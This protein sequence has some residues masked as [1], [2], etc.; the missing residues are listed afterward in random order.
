MEIIF[1]MSAFLILYTYAVYPLML[2]VFFRPK[3]KDYRPQAENPEPSMVTILVCAHNEEKVI[4]ERID[5]LLSLDYPKE[6]TEIVIAS[7]G[8][9]DDTDNIVKEY[10]DAGV[11]LL[12]FS[13][14]AGKVNTINRSLSDL[15]GDIIVLTDANTIFERDAV[16]RLIEKFKYKDIGC[17][18]G[19]LHFRD[20]GI[21]RL[22]GIYWRFE[23]FLKK[24]EGARGSLL[25][26]NGGIYAFR[27]ELFINLPNDTIVE[28]FVL[29]MKILEKGH[30]VYYE[31]LAI[32][33]EDAAQ[34]LVQEFER[35]VRIG[36]GDY[37]A[38]VYTWKILNPLRGFT[39]FAYFSHKVVRWFVPFFIISLF[40]TNLFLVNHFF[41]RMVFMSQIIFYITAGLGN[42]L[43]RIDFKCKYI[44][45]PYYF[46]SMNT[47]LLIGFFR[48]CLGRQSVKWIRTQR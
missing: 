41:Y 35:R 2:A 16:S 23:Q 45:L 12:S 40:F 39:A 21:G 24:T 3:D 43:H 38:L 42:V 7:D 44:E 36:A 10:K 34:K 47:A 27:K 29:P 46:V 15:N 13:D 14:R 4:R 8:S 9:C 48:F 28:D 25:G 19:E 22:E 18:V 33:Y 6:K 37:Q 17:V 32:A 20:E 1:W 26:A 31:P 30:K 11:R 5:N